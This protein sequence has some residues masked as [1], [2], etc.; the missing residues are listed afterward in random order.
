[1]TECVNMNPTFPDD[2]C[3]SV[4]LVIHNLT[5]WSHTTKH[6]AILLPPTSLM[7]ATLSFLQ[8]LCPA[9]AAIRMFPL[10]QTLYF[11]II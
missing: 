5:R 3:I 6:T 2:S 7:L 10:L 8:Y 9:L 1:M 11:A 4:C